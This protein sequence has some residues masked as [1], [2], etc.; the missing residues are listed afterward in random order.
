M[1]NL[2]FAIMI[3]SSVLGIFL[4]LAVF[5]AL[6]DAL[7]HADRIRRYQQSGYVGS[8]VKHWYRVN[9]TQRVYK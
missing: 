1:S 5:A 2:F 6:F 4:I 3:A 9:Q 7:T 8:D